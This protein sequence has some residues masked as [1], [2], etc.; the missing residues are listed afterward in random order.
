M[1]VELPTFLLPAFVGVPATPP[2]KLAL[3]RANQRM[4]KFLLRLETI[5]DGELSIDEPGVVADAVKDANRTLRAI[6]HALHEIAKYEAIRPRL[7][8]KRRMAGYRH[9]LAEFKERTLEP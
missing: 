3:M 7:D 6:D 2:E 5:K 4:E 8:E 9:Y 1:P